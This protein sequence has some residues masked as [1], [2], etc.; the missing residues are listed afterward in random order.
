VSGRIGG[1]STSEKLSNEDTYKIAVRNIFREQLPR[2]LTNY[3]YKGSANGIFLRG[4]QRARDEIQ[5]VFAIAGREY[6]DR[7]LSQQY[8]E[9]NLRKYSEMTEAENRKFVSLI[10]FACWIFSFFR[11]A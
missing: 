8:F 9:E 10:S 4:I 2:E 3:V 7:R 11:Q 6:P 1:W 5:H